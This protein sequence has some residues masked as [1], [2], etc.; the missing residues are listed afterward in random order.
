MSIKW[1]M[2]KLKIVYSYDGTLFC[3]K[4]EL[5]TAVCYNMDKSWTYYTKWKKPVQK[6][7][8]MGWLFIWNVQNRQIYRDRK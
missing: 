4:K 3:N 2:G 6:R 8:C 1:W 5:S 7:L